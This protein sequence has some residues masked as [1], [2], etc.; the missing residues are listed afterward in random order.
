M[1]REVGDEVPGT[2]AVGRLFEI[3]FENQRAVVSESGATLRVYDVGDRP[4][5]EPFDGPD[6]PVIGCQGE[7]LAPWPNR[8]VDGRW[9]WGSSTHQLSITEPERGHAIHGLVRTLPWSVTGDQQHGIGLEATL[10]AHPGWPFPLRFAVVYSL[11]TGGLTCRLYATNIGRTSCPYGAATH[12]Y[13]AVPGGTVDAVSVEIPA[14]KFLHTDDR[15]A[16]VELRSVEG[17]AY[18]FDLARPVG[19]R[20]AD[21]A[22]TDLERLPDGRVEARIKCPDGRT[23]VVWGDSSV[24]WWQ[25]Y[26]GDTLPPPWPRRAL[27]LEPMTCGPDALNTGTDLVVLG[28]GETHTM[29]W[30]VSVR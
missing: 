24:R 21:T 3:S 17:T 22:F 2:S 20:Q 19:S 29:T 5:V 11:G 14:G 10:L 13:F 16:P 30:G 26:T 28:P 12:P 18:E 4:V 9:R 6:T 1:A 7:L 25:L 15:L 27:A 8:T 23:T